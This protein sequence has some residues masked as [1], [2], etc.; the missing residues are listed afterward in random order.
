MVATK[1]SEDCT[2][3]PCCQCGYAGQDSDG[4]DCYE[5]GGPSIDK[6]GGKIWGEHC[7]CW[8]ASEVECP[9][10][11]DPQAREM[12]EDLHLDPCPV[13]GRSILRGAP[14]HGAPAVNVDAK[15]APQRGRA[16]RVLVG[17]LLIGSLLAIPVFLPGVAAENPTNANVYAGDAHAIGTS[18]AGSREYAI[19]TA[20]DAAAPTHRTWEVAPGASITLYF[21]SWT[22]GVSPPLLCCTGGDANDLCLIETLFD[23][24]ATVQRTLKNSGSCDPDGTSYTLYCTTSGT[25][26]GTPIAGTLR[27]H[28]RV[29]EYTAS[30]TIQVYDADSASAD[31]GA[32]RCG[33]DAATVTHGGYPTG[34]TYAYTVAGE[35]ITVSATHTNRATGQTASSL[36]FT[37]YD[38]GTP[39]GS[40]ATVS[41]STSGTT[42]TSTTVSDT[43]PA[44][45]TSVTVAVGISGNSGLTGVKWTAV[46]T[47]T[48]PIVKQDIVVFYKTATFTVDPRITATHLMQLNSGTFATPPMSA[49]AGATRINTDRGYIATRFTN[50]RSEGL[51]GASFAFTRT[52]QDSGAVVPADTA[53]GLAIATQGGQAGWGPL[54]LW[55]AGAPTGTWT[56]TIDVTAP[57]TIDADT[58][59]ISATKTYTLSAPTAP[60]VAAGDPLRIKCSPDPA[61]ASQTVLCILTETNADGSARTGN[62][63][64][65]LVDVYN[66]SFSIIVTGGATTEIANGVYRYTYTV[67]ASPTLGTYPVIARTM[68]ASV[69]PAG[70]SFTVIA[71]PTTYATPSDVTTAVSSING[72]VDSQL[73]TE[74]T[75]IDA[76]VDSQLATERTTI[77]AHTDAKVDAAVT[78]LDA[79]TLSVVNA[80]RDL[81]R[82]DLSTLTATIGSSTDLSTAPTVF[83][84]IALAHEHADANDAATQALI[85]H[86][87]AHL[88]TLVDKID[89]LNLTIMGDI[90]MDYTAFANITTELLELHEHL[91]VITA[92]ITAHIGDPLTLQGEPLEVQST[93]FPVLMELAPLP[94]GIVLNVLA[95]RRKDQQMRSV[96]FL[97]AACTFIAGCVA[98]N[99]YSMPLRVLALLWGIIMLVSMQQKK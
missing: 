71:T 94:L 13:T 90:I 37:L 86:N 74:R 67:S 11:G 79:Y 76:H 98:M 61:I 87:E 8:H 45:S 29:R 18:G 62:A 96:L 10:H 28:I 54:A 12:F 35:T 59:L 92:N 44:A 19:R 55:N 64:G 89:H 23:A 66:P 51:S 82:G 20:N 58:Y 99:H 78:T 63:A 42:S 9:R 21:R 3:V 60:T 24:S 75:T 53:T 30:N 84:K 70:G 26:G 65:T 41:A 95:A 47:V 88:H 56:K 97:L 91:H 16:A 5:K 40:S 34:P 32:I 25:S 15:P 49:D 72:H 36:I 48:S 33:L 27:L 39:I 1:S 68:D 57:S 73:A 4:A 14:E 7:F 50:A 80:A 17:A 46:N 69:V 43:F 85:T 83:G 81:I 6:G 52:L 77:N 22:T 38:G 2:C 93:D 31:K